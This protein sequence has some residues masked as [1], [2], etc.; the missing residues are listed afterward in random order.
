[1]PRYVAL[2]RGINVGGKNLIA[3]PRLRSCFEAQGFADVATYIQSGNVLFSAN[4]EA[5][6]LVERIEAELTTKFGYAASVVL[7]SKP[8]MRKI[9]DDAPKG[10][11]TEPELYRYDVLFLKEPLKSAEA[12]A[13]VAT[14]AGVDQAFAGRGVLYFSRLIEKA[15]QSQLSRLV[16]SPIYKRVTIRNWNTTKRLSELICGTPIAPS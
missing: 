2:L 5:S 4:D 13:A 14:R 15:S 8:Q 6:P 7:R 11:G 16:S 12:M 1:M 9:V 3:M 10:F